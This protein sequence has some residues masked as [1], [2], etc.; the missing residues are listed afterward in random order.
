[1]KLKSPT[2]SGLPKPHEQN[3]GADCIANLDEQ[4]DSGTRYVV[5]RMTLARGARRRY[6]DA[7]KAIV[8]SAALMPNASVYHQFSA[9]QARL[10]EVFG[11]AVDYVVMKSIS[12]QKAQRTTQKAQIIFG[13][14]S[15]SEFLCT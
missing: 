12:I 6:V 1:M 13:L 2:V 10:P 8:R 3:A 11:T 14:R 4:P 5:R 9:A 15:V 7:V